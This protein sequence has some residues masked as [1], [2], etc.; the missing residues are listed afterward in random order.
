MMSLLGGKDY[1]Y[2]PFDHIENTLLQPSCD[3]IMDLVIANGNKAKGISR[4]LQHFGIPQGNY[5]AFGDNLNDK[6]M[7]QEAEIGVAMGNCTPELKAYA[8]LCMRTK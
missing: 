6:E 3:E 7:L 2:S 5:M 4:L 1:D 8:K